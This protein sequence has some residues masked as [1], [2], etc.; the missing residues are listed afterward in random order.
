[1]RKSLSLTMLSHLASSAAPTGAEHSLALLA[2]S[3]AARAHR[4]T[5]VAPGRWSLG[6]TLGRH[7]VRV[8]I[9]PCRM[10]WLTHYDEV[11]R[12]RLAVKWAR[13]LWP[14]AGDRKLREFLASPLPDVLHVNCLPHVK[15]ARAARETGR[16]VVWHVR[17]IL[18]VGPR[19]SWF[20]GEIK[21]NADAVV[22]VSEAVAAWL[23]EEGLGSRVRVI[24]N[25]VE[26]PEDEPWTAEARR[27]LG[28]PADGCLFGLV[29][30]L[31]PHKGVREFLRAAQLASDEEPSMRF[32]LAGQGP[33]SFVKAVRSEI[34][35]TAAH[36]RIHW[37]P[38]RANPS[39]LYAA[40]D[41]V[42]LTTLSPDPLPRSVMEAM[43][44]GRPVAAFRSGGVPE[45]VIH[46]E[47]GLLVEP[48]NVSALAKIFARLARDSALRRGLGASG[49]SRAQQEFSAAVHA[50][51]M[52]DLFLELAG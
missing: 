43:A 7:G 26:I 20:A 47:T 18:P 25:G 37:L 2:R 29:G 10:A 33:S 46:G 4:V 3:L 31:L 44:H 45:M 40:A 41:V 36:A 5:V 39:E 12:L 17:E 34:A 11:P 30:Q 15:G 38:P 13:F 23:R 19:R 6:E 35:R 42:A 1:M 14:D 51:R 32:F 16:P 48:G 52:E 27:R 50:E 49:R 9:V 28:I 8:A 21:R 22:A 24:P